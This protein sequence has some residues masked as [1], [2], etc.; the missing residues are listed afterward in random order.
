MAKLIEES[1]A[2]SESTDLRT[3]RSKA[4]FPVLAGAVGRLPG[5]NVPARDRGSA[6]AGVQTPPKSPVDNHERRGKCVTPPGAD[7]AGKP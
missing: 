5:A 6:T 1:Y 4:R 3:D 2:S 7:R